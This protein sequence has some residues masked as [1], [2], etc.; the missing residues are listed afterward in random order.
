MRQEIMPHVPTNEHA[1]Q[2]TT[3]VTAFF[4]SAKEHS[5]SRVKK[6]ARIAIAGATLT[7]GTLGP[8]GCGDNTREGSAH[9][10][11]TP[12]PSTTLA[13]PR[14]TAE[15]QT[16]TPFPTI[17]AKPEAVKQEQD[18][19]QSTQYPYEILLP[20]GWRPNTDLSYE[21]LPMDVYEKD[22]SD[23]SEYAKVEIYAK[24]ATAE[25]QSYVDIL[26]TYRFD[27]IKLYDPQRVKRPTVETIT[28]GKRQVQII[29]ARLKDTPDIY[30][31]TYMFI[32]KGK[33]W[34]ITYENNLTDNI[35]D[36]KAFQE[37]NVMIASFETRK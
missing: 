12:T 2:H 16:V 26:E 7:A 15:V 27:Q 31:R 25:L 23:P 35:E 14:S 1:T 6:S 20:D 9:T 33:V 29:L 8:V 3:R 30:L 34:Y 5:F 32:E 24:P 18:K 17:A 28:I 13:Q 36:D 10:Y 37:F 22:V 4:S 19:F 11:E 21:H